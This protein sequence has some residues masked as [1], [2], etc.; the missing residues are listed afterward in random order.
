MRYILVLFVAILFPLSSFAQCEEDQLVCPTC[1]PIV[2]NFGNGD[3]QLSGADA[4]VFFDLAATGQPFHV[5]WTALGADEAFLCLDRNGDGSITNG[6][7]LF[8]SVTP[9]R[10]GSRAGNGFVALADIDDNHDGV[11]DNRDG[12]WQQLLLWRDLNHDGISQSNEL[13][14]IAD[15]DVTAIDL[16]FHWSGRRDR[17]GNVFRYQSTVWMRSISGQPTPRTLYDIFFVRVR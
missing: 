3:C 11:I 10:D 16:N 2:I 7:E 9:L 13:T 5:G 6:T 17:W 12:V 1:S 15:S 4:P 14:R 8:G